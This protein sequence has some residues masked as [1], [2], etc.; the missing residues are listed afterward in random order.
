M[1]IVEVER[2]KPQALQAGFAGLHHIL[3]APIHTIGTCVAARSDTG[4]N[5]VNGRPEYVVQACEASLQRLGLETLD[6]YYVHRIDPTVPIED[7][8]GAMS[9]LVK[10]GKVREIG[11][12]EAHPATIRRAHAWARR[13]VAG[14]ASHKP[15]SRTLPC[16]TN[17]DM[18]PTVSSIGTVGSMR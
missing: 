3:G 7:T 11:L 10:Q 4:A 1:N 6:L 8:V 17:C 18:A 13:M 2:L 14:C 12:C 15:I 9:Q 16:F 5:G